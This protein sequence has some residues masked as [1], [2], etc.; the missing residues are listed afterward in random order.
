MPLKPPIYRKVAREKAT[1]QAA[2]NA[3]KLAVYNELLATL[4]RW[5]TA[6]GF[7]ASAKVIEGNRTMTQHRHKPGYPLHPWKCSVC[8][9]T[10]QRNAYKPW[11]Y[12]N[13]WSNGP[14]C[15]GVKKE[16]G[17]TP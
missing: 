6:M 4:Q 12:P 13:P 17:A 9:A 7:P 16:K 2:Q 15:P 14:W 8:G 5:Y 1:Q 3:H 10:R 11:T